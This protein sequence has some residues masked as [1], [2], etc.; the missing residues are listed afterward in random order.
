[1]L[2]ESINLIRSAFAL[3]LNIF[4]FIFPTL[5]ISHNSNANKNKKRQSQTRECMIVNN[6]NDNDNYN[7]TKERY[8][9]MNW[10]QIDGFDWKERRNAFSHLLCC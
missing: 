5:D 2:I 9:S 4:P 10:C 6:D 1:M 3:K 8:V 7:E